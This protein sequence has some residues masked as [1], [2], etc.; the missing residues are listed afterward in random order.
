MSPARPAEALDFSGFA[1]CSGTDWCA[2]PAN[3]EVM[4]KEKTKGLTIAGG[5]S[6]ITQRRRRIVKLR[7]DLITKKLHQVQR[8]GEFAGLAAE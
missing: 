5:L 1:G 2:H 7:L 6:T 4:A 8:P 3:S